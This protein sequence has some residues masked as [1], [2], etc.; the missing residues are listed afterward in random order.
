MFA[1]HRAA[2]AGGTDDAAGGKL[3]C[4]ERGMPPQSS[5]Q[6]SDR[7]LLDATV[8]AARDE[9]RATAD[10]VALLSEVDARRLYLGEGCASLFS[11]CTRILH[12]S[13]HAAYHRIEAARAARRFPIVLTLLSEGALTLTT[14]ALLRP[15]LTPDNHAAVLA[16]ARYRSRR[17]VEQQ[18]AALAPRPDVMPLV[19][20]IP[21]PT[22]SALPP[23]EM[24]TAVA[25]DELDMTPSLLAPPPCD[26][27][28]L[29]A[30]DA[31][32]PASRHVSASDTGGAVLARAPAPRPAAQLAPL[33]PDRYLLRITISAETYARLRRAQ[34]LLAHA[35][36]NRDP[37]AVLDRA[38]TELVAK[39][40]RTKLAARRLNR[41]CRQAID[42]SSEPPPAANRIG[43][44]QDTSP[45]SLTLFP[46]SGTPSR[47]VPATVRRA[48][49][50]RD[51]GRCA[52][53]GAHG[54]CAE[55]SRLELHHVV[56]FAAG[57]PTT[58]ANLALRCRAHNG[59]E[60][61]QRFGPWPG[62]SGDERG[63]TA[64]A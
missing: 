6:L 47:H 16:A 50:A 13:E 21:A 12:L 59:F 58:V 41:A 55:T 2:I 46:S 57:G 53:H 1:R 23:T 26:G 29:T 15:H 20:R 8:Q 31:A 44:A 40:E 42:R 49:W 51:Q 30:R 45:T 7:A 17:E 25:P 11:Y 64:R 14:V 54:R 18:V 56:P 36:P 4:Y 22:C 19:R 43:R 52:F 32:A 9:R 37:A 24:S 5:T 63:P 3:A 60:S 62:R 35:V 28:A 61:E 34:D 27:S 10:L 33:A 39:L 38:L 48:V